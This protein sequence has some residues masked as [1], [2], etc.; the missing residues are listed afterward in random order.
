MRLSLLLMIAVVAVGVGATSAAQQKTCPGAP[1]TRLIVG[2]QGQLSTS[3]PDEGTVAVRLRETPGKSGRIV[4][5]VDAGSAFK[6]L[7]GPQ[8]ADGYAWWQV[9]SEGTL[10]W[11][12]EGDRTGYFVEPVNGASVQTTT[13]VT[14]N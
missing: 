3:S 13:D 6:V 1:A 2:G 11:L 9:V 5:Q 12:A 8:C 4:G 7:S 14:P 10:G